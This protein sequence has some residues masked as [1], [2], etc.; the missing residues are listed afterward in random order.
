MIMANSGECE[1]C[2]RKIKSGYDLCVGC[3]RKRGKIID[4]CVG[5]GLSYE[6]AV[7]RA[8]VCYPVRCKDVLMSKDGRR[9]VLVNDCWVRQG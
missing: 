5:A 4:D 8:K 2:G 7:A 6:A 1:V 9:W 3:Q